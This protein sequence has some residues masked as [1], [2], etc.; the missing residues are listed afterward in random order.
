[1]ITS[2]LTE[3]ATSRTAELAGQPVEAN[4]KE[5]RLSKRLKET[6]QKR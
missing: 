4:N 5:P 2:A 1:M 6:R 3:L